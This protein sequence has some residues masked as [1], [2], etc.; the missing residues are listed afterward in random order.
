M[1]QRRRIA[2]HEGNAVALRNSGRGEAARGLISADQSV[3]LVLR[4]QARGQLL[5]ERRVA[6]MIDEDQ[7][8]LGAAQIRQACRCG[9]RQVAELGMR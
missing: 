9:E 5:R 1:L 4:D 3:H 2:D 8:E 6:L 7:L